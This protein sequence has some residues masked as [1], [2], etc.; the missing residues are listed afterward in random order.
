MRLERSKRVEHEGRIYYLC[1]S[2]CSSFPFWVVWADKGLE[3]LPNGREIRRLVPYTGETDIA[4]LEAAFDG[5]SDTK[6]R[7]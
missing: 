6:K 7:M 2:Q 1:P 5:E 3:T 4:A